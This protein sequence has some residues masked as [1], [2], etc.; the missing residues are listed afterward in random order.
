MT[1]PTPTQS[2][3]TDLRELV[4]DLAEL[5]AGELDLDTPFAAVDID[6]LLAMEIAVHVERLCGV[7]F[8]DTELKAVQ[9]VRQ[10]VDAVRSK[11]P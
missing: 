2:L 5:P 3:E 11:Q 6:S 10:L 7:R 1:T 8:D 4:A 9:S